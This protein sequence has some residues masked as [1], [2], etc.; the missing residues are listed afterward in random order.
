ML[1]SKSQAQPQCRTA[2][3]V[4]AE[5][6]RLVFNNGGKCVTC[7][8]GDKFTDAN[9]Q[10]HSPSEAVSEPEPNSAQLRIAQRQAVP[11]RR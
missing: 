9:S 11:N 8:S 2:R 7:H 5:R 6:G 1:S 3:A 4:A 10:L